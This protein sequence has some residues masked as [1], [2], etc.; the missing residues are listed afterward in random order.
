[1]PGLLVGRVPVCWKWGRE[2]EPQQD[3][4]KVFKKTSDKQWLES[5]GD[6]NRRSKT[7]LL[8][9]CALRKFARDRW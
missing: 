9:R 5:A 7:L 3:H 1:M 2:L 4:Q 8:E 6:N